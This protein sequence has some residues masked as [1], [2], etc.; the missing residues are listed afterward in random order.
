[1]LQPK[2]Q[3]FGHLMTAPGRLSF[4]PHHGTFVVVQLPS[5]VRLFVTPRTAAHHQDSLSITISQ[6]LPKFMSTASVIPF[7]DHCLVVVKG[8]A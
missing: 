3:D 7:T 8:L 6:S 4:S 1:M 5:C 2:H